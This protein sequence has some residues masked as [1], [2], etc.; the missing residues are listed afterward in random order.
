MLTE[1]MLALKVGAHMTLR[2]MT[3]SQ[4]L[5]AAAYDPMCITARRRHPSPARA[6]GDP[7]LAVGGLPTKPPKPDC[8]HAPH[9]SLGTSL[10]AAHVRG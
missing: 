7:V 10:P 9:S 6:S 8:A 5:V 1:M 4:V 2:K 3:D